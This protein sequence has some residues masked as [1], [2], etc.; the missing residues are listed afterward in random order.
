VHLG[1]LWRPLQPVAA[2]GHEASPALVEAV[3]AERAAPDDEEV[4]IVWTG[5]EGKSGRAEPT[6][7]LFRAA[8]SE[9]LIAGY[10]FDHSEEV[11]GE[12]H[13]VMRQRGVET[14]T[15]LHMQ[16]A[17]TGAD[18]RVWVKRQVRALLLVDWKT[19]PYLRIYIAPHALEAPA[20]KPVRKMRCSGP[21]RR[22]CGLCELHATR[23]GE[24]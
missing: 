7:R 6:P 2:L 19:L 10:R 15:F 3:L 1:D 4:S 17:P 24:E 8:G 22:Y 20:R 5:P 23:A 21:A 9:V 16:P 13:T 12:L 14:E 11:L 18:A